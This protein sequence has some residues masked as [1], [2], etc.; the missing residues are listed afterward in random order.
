MSTGLLAYLTPLN[1]QTTLETLPLKACT[2][3]PPRTYSKILKSKSSSRKLRVPQ[4]F[5]LSFA[6]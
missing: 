4:C 3:S 6:N 2:N 1:E 5:S